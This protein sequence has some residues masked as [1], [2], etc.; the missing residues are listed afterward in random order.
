MGVEVG[1]A[2]LLSWTSRRVVGDE[3]VKRVSELS[4][5]IRIT[6]MNVLLVEVVG[7]SIGD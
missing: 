1:R 7:G 4:G 3:R 5:S 2:S 6:K